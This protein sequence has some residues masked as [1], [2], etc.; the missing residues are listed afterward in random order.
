MASNAVAARLEVID[1][2]DQVLAS[3]PLTANAI[4]IGRS[5]HCAV[6]IDDPHIAPRHCS[7]VL[8]ANGIVQLDVLPSVNGVQRI[9]KSG[10]A[11]LQ[12]S[13]VV[14]QTV[15]LLGTTRL[16]VRI[17]D[18]T[19]LAPEIAIAAATLALNGSD[20][21]KQAEPRSYR[22]TW[23][24]ITA[25]LGLIYL[26]ELIGFYT[27][28]TGEP[29]LAAVLSSMLGLALFIGAWTA[30][31]SILSRIFSGETKFKGHLLIALLAVLISSIWNEILDLLG[32]GFSLRQVDLLDTISR[33]FVATLASYFH[34]KLISTER[35]FQKGA[36]L[37]ATFFVGLG[38]LGLVQFDQIKRLRQSAIYS[39]SKPAA[40]ELKASKSLEQVIDQFNAEKIIIDVQRKEKPPEASDFSFF[41][42]D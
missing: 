21:A 18:Q 35:L 25:V 3:Y 39:A 34:L 7:L 40:F 27:R 2:A 10:S 9:D 4:V 24:K 14:D 23:L 19:Q 8:D 32:F 37:A 6:W 42:D 29:K 13:E 38:I 41:D 36:G 15:L 26:I 1:A 11:A 5:M 22:T 12:S 20:R 31:W 16:R 28:L 17:Q 30:G 33:V